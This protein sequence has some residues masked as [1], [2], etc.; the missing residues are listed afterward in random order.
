MLVPKKIK[1]NN[2]LLHQILKQNTESNFYFKIFKYNIETHFI[3]YNKLMYLINDKISIDI[4][5]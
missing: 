5:F 3:D 1:Q 2:I 4:T